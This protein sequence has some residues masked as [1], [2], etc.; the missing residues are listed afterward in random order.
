MGEESENRN[1]G[2]GYT[3]IVGR[4]TKVKL[5]ILERHN[6]GWSNSIYVKDGKGRDEQKS[7]SR[8]L[9]R[10]KEIMYTNVQTPEEIAPQKEIKRC[11]RLFKEKVT[12]AKRGKK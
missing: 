9:R 12:F 2:R 5:S 10:R 1:V 4:E 3:T 7:L 6:V 11:L 8:L